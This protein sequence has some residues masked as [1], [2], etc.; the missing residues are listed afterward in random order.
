MRNFYKC[1]YDQR[2]YQNRYRSESSDRRMIKVG[3][4]L[5]KDNIK[6]ILGGMIEVAVVS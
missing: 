2:N 3:V 4:G 1:N 5:E 6:V